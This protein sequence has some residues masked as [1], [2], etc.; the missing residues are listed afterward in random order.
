[1]R[2]RALP[3]PIKQSNLPL[4]P[5]DHIN[6][7]YFDFRPFQRIG[8]EFLVAFAAA[9]VK[10]SSTVAAGTAGSAFSTAVNFLKWLDVNQTQVPRLISA[11]RA[12]F[13]QADPKDWEAAVNIWKDQI[14][15]KDTIQNV[16]KFNYIKGLGGILRR[17]FIFGVIPRF[18]LART[19]RNL[20]QSRAT[21]T[22]A[23]VTSP[24]SKTAILK[25]LGQTLNNSKTKDNDS[26]AKRDFLMTLVAETGAIR[27]T[28]YEQ[29]AELMRI[30]RDRL[31]TIRRCAEEDFLKWVTW[32]EDGQRALIDSD[33][34]FEQ[35]DSALTSKVYGSFGPFSVDLFPDS[36]PGLSLSRLLTFLSFQAN[37]CG[38]MLMQSR[39]MFP[40]RI[41]QQVRRFGGP[42][43]VQ[44]HL[45]PHALLTNAVLVIIL[46]DTGA[47]VSVARTLSKNCLEN[48]EDQKYKIIKGTKRRSCGKLIVDELPVTDP[49]HRVSS[50][51]AVE[52]YL[53]IS[54]SLR[55]L[56]SPEDCNFLFLR[57]M[58]YSMFRST[59]VSALNEGIPIRWFR[60]F[61]KE[62]KEISA[63]PL[64]L[65]MI[66]PSVLMQTSFD[67]KAGIIAAAALGD[68]NSLQTTNI[69]V[70][71]YPNRLAWENM[72]RKFQSLFQAVSIHTIKGAAQKL[73]ISQSHAK[74]L[75]GEACR[76]GLGVAC[77]DPK[78]GIQPG[79]EKGKTCTQ[80]QSC[81]RCSNS[82][83]VA[84]ESNLRDL[85]IWNNH[86]EQNRR[87][88][89]VNQPEKW[90][91]DW[92][93]WLV[94]T[95]VVLERAARG[96][97]AKQF[98]EASGLAHKMIVN[99]E[100]N[101][102]LLW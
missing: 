35:V 87:E 5:Y 56:A 42:E 23:E 15:A 88:W 65:K 63:L 12:D 17:M 78:S 50:V 81:H 98:K 76:T 97:T 8:Y 11:L 62:H 19:P 85:I 93:P 92:L 102:P 32:W 84:T 54:E 75:F 70:N 18:Y 46:C 94:F 34:S 69:Y 68:H 101:L 47:N 7:R 30:N 49:V 20:R 40:R 21:K 38:R 14:I 83:V 48:S 99:K 72:I 67:N 79:S 91:K 41:Q 22:V 90:E 53:M 31:L 55:K 6:G 16:T 89:E 2:G 71:R 24:D 36:N 74:K 51:C 100:V 28:P 52:T 96:R 29:A 86:L 4:R 77:L 82:F 57:P 73:G 3:A 13:E 9:F 60:R 80:L 45:F 66:R 27:G 61:R 95:R 64:Q 37:H 1:M 58:S 59:G 26:E 39:E 33:L 44:A 10:Y 25:I 43:V